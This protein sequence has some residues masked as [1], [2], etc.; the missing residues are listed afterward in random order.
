[1]QLKH[2]LLLVLLAGYICTF[3]TRAAAL[4]FTDI[5]GGQNSV[6]KKVDADGNSMSNF[7]TGV[8]HPRGI[9]ID[10]DGRKLYWNDL[11]SGAMRR[12]SL[13]DPSINEKVV[14]IPN[15]AAGVALDP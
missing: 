7:V 14:D 10:L 3:S 4:Y 15:T 1:M 12:V 11:G 2:R 6:I 8:S 13:D 5:E 9:A